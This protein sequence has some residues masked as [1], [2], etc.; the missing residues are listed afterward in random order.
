MMS[1]GRETD[2][3]KTVSNVRAGPTWKPLELPCGTAQVQNVRT[4]DCGG[5]VANCLLHIN[6]H[7]PTEHL[8]IYGLY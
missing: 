8:K 6:Q 1:Q 3:D 2:A 5:A 4:R 7:L